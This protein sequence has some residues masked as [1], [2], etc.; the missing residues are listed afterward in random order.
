MK[1]KKKTRGYAE[2]L[3]EL[4]ETIEKMGRGDIPIDELEDTVKSASE[5]IRYLRE[6][7]RATEMEITRVLG[8]IERDTSGGAKSD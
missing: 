7:L 5:K 2:V 6:R 4:E 1:T 3:R 8:E